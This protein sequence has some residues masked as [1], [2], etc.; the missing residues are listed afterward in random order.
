MERG[1]APSFQLMLVVVCLL[2]VYFIGT[3]NLKNDPQYDCIRIS[4]RSRIR[5]LERHLDDSRWLCYANHLEPQSPRQTTAI[6]L[7]IDLSD[8]RRRNTRK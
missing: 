4:R 1:R 6:S 5:L 2:F 3:A 7:D 8:S